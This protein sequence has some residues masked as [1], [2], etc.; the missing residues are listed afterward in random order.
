MIAVRLLFVFAALSIVVCLAIYGITRHKKYLKIAWRILQFFIMVLAC[1]ILF[2]LVE[3][4]IL[5]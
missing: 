4:L 5:I 1:F 2:Y 3:R